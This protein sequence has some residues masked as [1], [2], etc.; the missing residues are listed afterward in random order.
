MLS[1]ASG[2]ADFLLEEA[3]VLDLFSGTGGIGIEALSRGADSVDF[4]EQDPACFRVLT[5][6]VRSCGYQSNCR[7]YRQPV[8]SFLK[9]K[10]GGP[11]AFDIVFADPP[12]HTSMIKKL[13]PQLE[14]GVKL[15]PLGLIII[16]H[17]HKI[18]LPDRLNSYGQIRSR[19]Y[20]DSVLSFYELN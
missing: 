13:L 2:V 1:T 19:R 4:V 9:E 3:R 16:E 12:Y 6:N 11:K 20:G 18:P 10:N 8:L 7:L 5:E 15:P 17:F 14:R